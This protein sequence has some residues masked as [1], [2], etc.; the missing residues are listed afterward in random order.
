MG[1]GTVRQVVKSLK[2]VQAIWKKICAHL[3]EE[4][5]LKKSISNEQGNQDSLV[6]L[7]NKAR[8]EW[9]QTQVLF[10][11]AQDPDL[12]D[13]AIYAMEAAKKKYI[14]LLKLAKKENISVE[15]VCAI[16]EHKTA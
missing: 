8:L 9:E 4:M 6:T 2:A 5:R 13:H 11:E 14:Y 3:T 10:E 15:K 16:E 7:V 12:I 1:C